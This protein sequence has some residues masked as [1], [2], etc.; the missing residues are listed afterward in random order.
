MKIFDCITYFDEPM[1][2]DLRLNILSEYVDKFIVIEAK[3]TH[4]GNDKKLNFE[5]NNFKKFKNKIIYKV[6][7]NQPKGIIEI[8]KYDDPGIQSANKR[9]NS[10]KRIELSYD[11]ALDCLIEANPEDLFI[12]SDSDEI[13]NLEKVN[14]GQ[15]NNKILIFKQKMF[16]YKFNLYYELIPWFGSRA[17][18]VRRLVTPTWLRYIKPKKYSL[19]RIDTWFSKTKYNSVKIIENGGWHFSN[20]KSPEDIEKKLFNF[21]HHNEVEE[22]GIDLEK[23]KEM[24]REKKVYYDHLADKTQQKHR[25]E[26][27]ELKRLDFSELPS[28]LIKNHET[29]KKWFDN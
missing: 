16:Y 23:I 14:F 19:L 25:I 2:F 26:G 4:S 17:C 28:Y 12:L 11:T 7:E 10:L 27:Y 18:T 22:S 5:I 8:N 1:L 24:V 20:V 21:G 15:I 6:I 9:M 29:Y 3:H 13:P